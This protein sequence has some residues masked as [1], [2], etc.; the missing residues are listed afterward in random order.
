MARFSPDFWG[1]RFPGFAFVPLFDALMFLTC[2][3][4]TNTT[5]WFLL[6]SFEDWCTKSFLMLAIFECNL[7]TR[8]F[9]LRQFLLNLILRAMRRCNFASFSRN[10]LSGW[11]WPTTSPLDRVTKLTTPQSIPTADLDGC[12]GVVPSRACCMAT[13]HLPRDSLW[14]SFFASPSTSC[15]LRY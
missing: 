15:D 14:G 9:A 4:S 11:H 10:F 13:N 3:S 8:A 1:T 5:A 6:M 12:C 7:T 2:K